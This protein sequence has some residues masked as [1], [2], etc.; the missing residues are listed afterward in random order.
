MTTISIR[1]T[2]QE[3]PVITG[4][5]ADENGIYR[6]IRLAPYVLSIPFPKK[7]WELVPVPFEFPTA[8]GARIT[9]V[10]RR[11]VKWRFIIDAVGDWQGDE[12]STYWS[13]G[14]L[15]ISF[16][17]LRVVDADPDWGDE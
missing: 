14:D 17:D 9:G 1:P 12:G 5:L 13:E 8:F 7:E 6:Y 15:P 10:D 3:A 16:T 4:E 11:G 2:G